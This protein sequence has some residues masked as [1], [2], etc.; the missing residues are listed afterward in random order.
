MDT[1]VVDNARGVDLK[2]GFH[3]PEFLCDLPDPDLAIGGTG[4]EQVGVLQSSHGADPGLLVVS[5]VVGVLDSQDG[6]L[7]VDVPNVQRRLVVAFI[8]KIY[9]KVLINTFNRA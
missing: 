4:R 7:L 6:L 1:N 3:V 9:Y 2:Q 5:V 8:K